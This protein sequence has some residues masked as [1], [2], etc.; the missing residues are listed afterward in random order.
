ML[1]C[2]KEEFYLPSDF[3]YLN[4]AYLS[5]QARRVEAA[6]LSGLRKKRNPIDIRPEDFFRDSN[7]VRTLFARLIHADEQSIAIVG[8]VSYGIATIARNLRV[9]PRQA[10]VVLHE[11]FPSNV[12]V[13][14]RL[15][16]DRN[17]RIVTVEPDSKRRAKV[18]NE[19]IIGAIDR[20]TAVVAVPNVH[21]T[22]GTIFDLEAISDRVR[23][24]GAALVVDGTQSVGALDFDVRRIK[25]DALICAGYKWLFGPYSTGLAYF[26]EKYHEGVP[27]EENWIT[28]RRSEEFSRLV[29]YEAAYQPGAVRFD[30]GE[31]SNFILLPMLAAALEMVHEWQPQRIQEYCRALTFDLV[32]EARELGY[33][34]GGEDDRADHLFGI[35]VPE[36]SDHRLLREELEKRRV[37]VS[38]RGNAVRVSPHVYNDAHDV[39][40]LLDALR[41]TAGVGV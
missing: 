23:D 33:E 19:R 29:D 10:I 2:Q 34:I 24:V 11:Q 17:A 28:R 7:R 4:C 5:P 36:G 38:L 8:S 25:P 15:A 6:G 40:A 39:T 41:A 21:W 13:W 18:W 35:R 30:V 16:A 12:Y 37:A 1:P 26:D 14:Q 9:E 20:D 22:D 27:L 3:H 32:R 31:R